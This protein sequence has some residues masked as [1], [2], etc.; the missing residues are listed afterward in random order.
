MNVAK[1]RPDSGPGDDQR[2]ASSDPR[3]I[4]SIVDDD[5]AMVDS[6]RTLLESV[7]HRVDDY[8]SARAFLER[9]DFANDAAGC[10][11]L[12][13]RMPGMTGHALH[14]ELVR[15]GC[16][17]PIIVCTAYAEV[18]LAVDAMRKGAISVVQK[19]FRPQVLLD[20]VH[21]AIH[22]DSLR[23]ERS[24]KRRAFDTRR[25]RLTERQCQVMALMVQGKPN[26]AIAAELGISERTVE[27]HRAR[28]LRTMNVDSTT[29]LAYLV[30]L[31][32][33]E[34]KD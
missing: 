4:V 18:D 31:H 12:D 16:R 13:E 24:A 28:V 20:A 34:L 21:E 14:D 23:H 33:G 19:P 25:A 22:R 26:K 1:G 6:L 11:I 8:L 30:A 7:G 9:F 15:R 5:E 3:P 2:A 17:T 27:L 29:Q 32:D 10:I